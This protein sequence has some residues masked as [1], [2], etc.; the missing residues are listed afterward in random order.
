M[1]AVVDILPKALT[2]GPISPRRTMSPINTSPFG[3]RVVT[4][5][6]PIP[7]GNRRTVQPITPFTSPVT[8]PGRFLPQSDVNSVNRIVSIPQVNRATP[9][10]PMSIPSARTV[11]TIKA[12]S[13]RRG[14]ATSFQYTQSISPP[15]YVNAVRPVSP[16]RPISPTRYVSAVR[17]ASPVRP[18]SPTR[19]A[20]AMRPASPPRPVMPVRPLSP[21][22]IP[23]SPIIN[24]Q[25]LQPNRSITTYNTSPPDSPRRM[26][27][28]SSTN[29]AFQAMNTRRL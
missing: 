19:Y 11:P 29:R 6:I 13:P 4:P 16:V 17:P 26:E 21:R 5:A 24:P 23:T 25:G 7:Q 27:L 10:V 22:T 9:T 3:S 8:P 1:E 15:R 2:P 20:S 12:I 18:I 14:T 28:T